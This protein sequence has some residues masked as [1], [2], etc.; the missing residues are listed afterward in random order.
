VISVIEAVALG[1]IQG[2]TEFL[3]VSSSGHLVLMQGILEV[4]GHNLFL[5]VMLHLGTLF[6]VLLYFKED[7][8]ALL[9]ALPK[10]VQVSQYRDYF[11]EDLHFRLLCLIALG[12]L[13]TVLIGFTLKDLFESLFASPLVVCF[14]LI[15]TGIMLFSAERIKNSTRPLSELRLGEGFFIGLMQGLAITPGISR[16]GSTISAALWQRISPEA[17]ARFSFLLSIPAIGGA[18]ILEGKDVWGHIPQEELF[19]ISL[20][21]LASFISGLLA[22]R[23]LMQLVVK[24]KLDYFAYYCWLVGIGGLLYYLQA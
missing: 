12:T 2:L 5:D 1:V 6:A 10:L 23:L 4:Q 17:A 20:G 18:F 15:L 11:R 3:P 22:L 13:P 19:A 14:T 7:V 21:T 8:I 24:R 9:K 16:S